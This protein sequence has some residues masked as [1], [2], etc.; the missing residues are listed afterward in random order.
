MKLDNNIKYRT[1]N[2]NNY[3]NESKNIPIL[4]N[5]FNYIKIDN[6]LNDEIL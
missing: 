6:N 2:T 3:F 1:Y 4:L 5:R